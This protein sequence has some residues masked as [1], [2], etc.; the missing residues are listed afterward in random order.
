M[1]DNT[2][3]EQQIKEE[4]KSVAY[5]T[6]EL[7]IEILVNKYITNL[8]SDKNDLYVPQYQREFVWDDERQSKFIESLILG[9]PIPL[10]FVAEDSETGRWEIVD[11]SQRIRTLAAFMGGNLQITGLQNLTELNGVKYTDL[12]T[13]RQ[14]K[15][16]NIPIRMVVL[17]EDTTDDVRKDIFERINRG[18]DVLKDM[19]KRKG[20]Y[21][22]AFCDFIYKECA[23]NT[24]FIALTP[25]SPFVESRQEHEEL[26]L[27]FFALEEAYPELKFTNDRIGIARYLDEYLDTMNKKVAEHPELLDE[28]RALFEQMINFVTAYFEHGFAKQNMKQVSRV[29]FEAISVGSIK[30]LEENP[31]LT[32]SRE[33]VANW[34]NTGELNRIVAGKYKTHSKSKIKERVNYV[35]EHLLNT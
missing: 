17:S 10:L 35:K 24:K 5:D 29:Y 18:S 23:K 27:R 16:K 25:L 15:F 4:K 9:L 32:C 26:I 20:I 1:A 8:E 22:G 33:S 21:K 19:E 3:I 12:T 7:T 11:G 6:R 2:K 14:N 34:L 28:K 31:H 30:A 13:S